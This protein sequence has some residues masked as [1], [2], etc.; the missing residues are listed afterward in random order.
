MPSG[1]A[2]RLAVVVSYVINPLVLPPVFFWWLGDSLDM[3]AEVTW[4]LVGLAVGFL[5]LLPLCVVAW[6]VWRGRAE[7]LE[8]RDR[9]KRL[10]IFLWTVG[11]GATAA[12]LADAV[13]PGVG[14]GALF[15]VF[16]L[17]AAV[18]ALI[19]RRIKVSIHAAG[20]AGLASMSGWFAWL[21]ALDSGMTFWALVAVPLVMWARVRSD[22]HTLGQ[23]ILGMAFGVLVP[24]L[25]LF[26]LAALGWLAL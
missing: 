15:A 11:F 6:M 17:N 1:W 19:N 4:T 5:G 16:P 9:S 13:V 12:F 22:A 8:V 20:I 24:V 10:P 18:L 25:E 14:A 26:A 2:Y 7:T 21:A 3:P 23:V